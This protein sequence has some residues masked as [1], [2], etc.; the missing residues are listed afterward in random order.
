VRHK[1]MTQGTLT[2]ANLAKLTQ[3]ANSDDRYDYWSFLANLGDN[4]AKLA[5]QVVTGESLFGYIANSYAASFATPGSA[6]SDP[7]DTQAWWGVGVDLMKADLDA[8]TQA[9]NPLSLSF[10]T[11]ETYHENVFSVSEL[12]P[13]AWTPYD[14]FL[15]YANVNNP[16]PNA[17]NWAA[18][19]QEWQNILSS[20]T[21]SATLT[22]LEDLA[23]GV[24]QGAATYAQA[25][26]WL[27]AVIPAS[28]AY[29][30]ELLQANGNSDF[31][32]LRNADYVDGWTYD[33]SSGGWYQLYDDNGALSNPIITFANA[34]QAQ[35]LNQE[36][37]ARIS[38]FG[39]NVLQ[40]T[41]SW[42][43][44][45]QNPSTTIDIGTQQLQGGSAVSGTDNEWIGGGVTY[46]YTGSVDA[47]A[48]GA[49]TVSSALFG[50]GPGSIV[51][52]DFDLCTAT[53]GASGYMGIKLPL[54]LSLYPGS[55]DGVDPPAPAFVAGS[56]QSYTVAVNV[57]DSVAQT[58]TL[59]LSGAPESDFELDTDS[60]LTALNS[61]G[62]FTVTIAAGDTFASF[63]LMNVGDAGSGASVQLT[64]AVSGP[65]NSDGGTVSSAPL[66]EG[67]V[68]PIDNP[69]TQPTAGTLYDDGPD[70]YNGTQFELYDSHGGQTE[71]GTPVSSAGSGNNFIIVTGVANDSVQGGSGNDTIY[72]N[73]GAGIADGGTDVIEGEG[74]QDVLFASNYT[75][76][77]GGTGPASV[78]IYGD[79]AVDIQTAI[80]DA[81]A[82]DATGQQGDLI[83]SQVANATIVGSTGNDLIVDVGNDLVVAGPGNETIVGGATAQG[84][85]QP[86]EYNAAFE[87]PDFIYPGLTWS[88]S[89]SGGHL[90]TAGVAVFGAYTTAPSGYEGN[91]D[92][93]GDPLGVTDST[94]FGGSGNDVIELSNGNNDVE[95]GTGSATVQGGM[96]SNTIVGGNG[97]NALYG[98]GGNDYITAGDGASLLAGFGGN[99]SLIGGAGSDNL[100]AGG[101]FNNWATAETGNNYVQAGSGNTTIWGSGGN[102][103]LIGGSGN[104]IIQGGAGN[105][106]IV[107][108]SGTE[109]INGGS[110]NNTIEVGGDGSDT[111]WAGTGNTTIYGGDGRDYLHGGSGTTVIY[112]GDGGADGA[113]SY[114][115]ADSGDTTIYGGDGVDLLV[116]GS[117]NDVIYAGDGGDTTTAST[118]YVGSGNTTVHG[119]DG[120]NVINGGSGTDVLYAGDGGIEGCATAVNAGSGVA[121]LYGGAGVSVLTDSLG[122]SD[123]LVG[124]DGTSDMYGIGND[125][126]V[127]GTGSDLMSGTGSNTYIF[128]AGVGNDEIADAGGT[129]TLD[130][131]HDDDPTDDVIVSA[132]I[133]ADGTPTLQISDG[134]TTVLVDGGLTSANVA[135]INFG[136]S[137]SYSLVGL[138]QATDAAGNAFD[139]VVARANGNLTF[140]TGNGDSL[141]GGAGQDTIS[142]WGNEDS[143]AAG[144]GGTAMYAEGADAQ[145]S[146]GTGSDTLAALGANS[147]LTGGSG[148]ETF[149][150]NNSSD[151][152]T[153]LGGAS[154]SLITSVSYTLPTNVDVATATG[155]GNVAIRG[156]ADATNVITGNAGNDTLTAGSQEDS[157]IAGTGV[158]TLVG[159]AGADTF[160]VNNAN[161]VI[162]LPHGGRNDTVESSVDY[163]L[164]QPMAALTLTGAGD[165]TGADHYG[166]ATITGNAGADT[167]IGGSGSDT[168][169]AGTGVDTLVTGTGKNTLVVNNADDVI[170]V[171]LGASGDTLSSS[172]SETLVGGLDTLELTGYGSLEGE[173]NDDA[174]NQITGNRGSDVLIAG[175]GSDTLTAGTGSDTLI[176]GS[177]TDLLDGR[178]GHNDTFVLDSGFGTATILLSS[179]GNTIQFGSGISASNLTVSTVV[180]SRGNLALRIADGSSVVTID[181]GTNNGRGAFNLPSENLNFQFAEGSQ[182]SFAQLLAAAQVQDSTLAGAGGNLVLSG[183]AGASLAGGAGSDTLIGAGDGDTLVAGLGNEVLY[184]LGSGDQLAGGMGSDTLYGYGGDDTLSAGSGMTTM[185][186]GGGSNTYTL[187]E[188]A[189]ATIYPDDGQGVQTLVLPEGISASDFTATE[190]SSGDLII[191]SA[192]GTSVVV[193]GYYSNPDAGIWVLADGTGSGQLLSSWLASQGSST[194]GGTGSVDPAY[195]NEITALRVAYSAD[196]ISIL[197]SLGQQGAQ[198]AYPWAAQHASQYTFNGVAVQN[199]TIPDG[200]G[201]ELPSSENYN[202][203]ETQTTTGYITVTTTEAVYSLVQHSATTFFVGPGLGFEFNGV[204]DYRLFPVYGA[205]GALSGYNVWMPAYT[206]MEQTGTTTVTRTE[207]V[208]Q[209]YTTETLG[210]TAYNITMQGNSWL[211]AD[212]PFVGTVNTGNGNVRVYLGLNEDLGHITYNAGQA[213][214]PGAFIQVGNGASDDIVGTGGVDTIAAGLGVDTIEASWGSTVYVPMSG[215]SIDTIDIVNAPYYGTGPYPHNTL[216]LP[217]GVTLENLQYR[218]FSGAA[219]DLDTSQYAGPAETLQ[220]TYGGS[221]VLLDFDAGAPSWQASGTQSWDTDGINYFQF[222]DGTVLT[223]AQ[224]IA[225]AGPVLDSSNYDPI[226]TQAIQTVSPGLSVAASSLFTTADASG[227]TVVDYQIVNNNALG[228]YFTLGGQTYGAG[229]DFEVTAGQLSQLQYVAGPLGS[230]PQFSVTAFDGLNWGPTQEISLT[231]GAPS[232]QATGADQ[233]IEATVADESVVGSAAGSDTLIGGFDGDE[234]DGESGYDTFDYN[235]GGGNETIAPTSD[236]NNNYDNT[237][238]F[239][240]GIA[241][242]ALTLGVTSDGVLAINTGNSNDNVT[243]STFD[244]FSP[245]WSMIN[246]FAFSGGLSLSLEQLIS[247][248]QPSSGS[249]YV[250]DFDLTVNYAFNTPGGPL[251]SMQ[252]VNSTGQVVVTTT[253]GTD[254][255]SDTK[256]Y[257]YNADGSEVIDDNKTAPNQTDLYDSETTLDSQGRVSTEMIYP[258]DGSSISDT[259]AYNADGSYQETVVT[260]PANGGTSTTVVYDYDS[261]GNLITGNQ[262][263]ASGPDQTVTGPANGPDTLTGGYAGDTLVGASGQDTFDY[264][265]GSGA[266]IISETAPTNSVTDNVV[267][268]GTGITV[269]A[270]SGSINADGSVTL[271]TGSGGDSITLEGFNPL[272]PLGSMPIQQFEFS[273]GSSLTFAQL[274]SQMQ[275]SGTEQDVTNANGTT[276]AYAF[277]A[278]G[279]PGGPNYYG[280]LLDAQGQLLQQ[281]IL[282]SDDSSETDS[283][284]RNADGSHSDTEVQTTAAG[285]V[286]TLVSG[287]DAQGNEI[288]YLE[289]DPEG[290]SNDLSWNTQG[291]KLSEVDTS[292]DGSSS[293]TTYSYN[294]DGSYTSTEVETPAGGGA[295]TTSVIDVDNQGN[296]ISDLETNPDGSSSDLSWNTQG[297]KLS[298]VDTSPDGSSLNTTYSYNADGSYVAMEVETP[299]GGGATTTSVIDVD[300]QGNIISDLETNP[301]GSS[302]DLS[303]NTQGQKLSE[304]DTWPDG[305]S[306]NTM[307]AYNVDGSLTTTEVETPAG[308]APATTEVA[309]YDSSG[310]QSNDNSF[311]PG[312]NGSYTDEWY[313]PDGSNGSY[314]WNSSTDEYRAGWNDANGTSWTDDY[315]YASGGSPGSTGVSFTE[316]YSDSAGDEGTRQYD[317]ATGATTVSWYSAATGTITGTV[318]DSGFIGL[319]N[320]GELTNTQ[321]DLGF[322]NPATNPTFQNFLTAH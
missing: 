82:S 260:T 83:V 155:S 93:F 259:D 28:L 274:L 223:R 186:G 120:I 283:Y 174:T 204:P 53:Y 258:S 52:Q 54:Q 216:V 316:T 175:S 131:S 18:A 47:D 252:G 306:S 273:D 231:V 302:S 198:I 22:N 303:W 178:S 308:G 45:V 244:V 7:D 76:S 278:D 292:P 99:N 295:T 284:S 58:V 214:P 140:D 115:S 195:T 41:S 50:S 272:N 213:L 219:G 271:S 123:Q 26:S 30:D 241:P 224:I 144:A 167:L 294:A 124:G 234:L 226:V 315:Q 111:V 73:F 165:L 208:V 168:L 163:V 9:A 313:K 44:S 268:F 222:S 81:N 192:D 157:L 184:G 132:G 56:S 179:L 285:A 311:T 116:G 17:N 193:K 134:N 27:A 257:A 65:N 203:Q 320:D 182:L 169:V 100:Y 91:Y 23:E 36:Q 250:A 24:Q 207:P 16:N 33:P 291:Q 181:D 309:S 161:D 200:G 62:T 80:A 135:S 276:T 151:V 35:S 307:F 158:D 205:G 314:W 103:T 112:V 210:F 255:N 267:Q 154:N 290:S 299:A 166:F 49:L 126:F 312:T 6:L 125:T 245:Y 176:A 247:E 228:A 170:E 243:L 269:S 263:Q 29:I 95:L 5:L 101:D 133:L 94:I 242:S 149:E 31:I 254:G 108:G 172:V 230:D 139:T 51:L 164:G 249:E 215:D 86:S 13:D 4:Y 128:N 59:T 183:Q 122:G 34:T 321:P 212:G 130:F 129:E 180:D 266:E 196:M 20:G 67:Y 121:T 211:S 75:A 137:Q 71:N 190:D 280:K 19:N 201:Q 14:P 261:S 107:G 279:G 61:D 90:L 46:S 153:A 25:R 109:S 236:I 265:A 322:F 72:A 197:K 39:S 113:P 43:A 289:T 248:V 38:E 3:Y 146:G 191:A 1:G 42:Q 152:I 256:S 148:N 160:V 221:T 97:N 188:G 147:T 240:A 189:S 40:M 98:G 68:E 173:G 209:T 110:G 220:L 32:S 270:I 106:S 85:G 105:E 238:Q 102:D 104:D 21:V 217:E 237:L 143:L 117:G 96:G 277:N 69:F 63:S 264:V 298:E 310:N 229:A 287:F 74:G 293:N 171:T 70:G 64:A 282:N 11:I 301:N 136:D 305:S 187:T 141:G 246:Q 150:I 239:G 185:Y 84:L 87:N 232:V 57:A 199:I 317:A 233:T 156:N 162:Q 319:Q 37:Q 297:Q 138:L 286:T 114:A 77:S 288:S 78:R 253:I 145:I 194:G 10:K 66:T 60:G 304:V 55:N 202:W 48:I 89:Y 2:P 159:G 119:G 92:S 281:Y 206:D 8:R 15:V 227:N 142:A 127:A 79:S 218:L 177:G 275:S 262:T 235:V 318:T 296:M 88:M 225:L 300:N 118:V 251:Y 12:P